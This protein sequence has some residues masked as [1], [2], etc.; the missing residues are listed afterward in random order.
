MLHFLFLCHLIL[1]S[2]KWMSG[3]LLYVMYVVTQK[4][5]NISKQFVV[6]HVKCFS[7][8][9]LNIIWFVSFKFNGEPRFIYLIGNK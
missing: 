7:V 2:K 1:L 9:M 8:E 6:L 4:D 3:T 5:K